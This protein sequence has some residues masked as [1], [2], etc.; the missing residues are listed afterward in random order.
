MPCRICSC[1][2]FACRDSMVSDSSESSVSE[3]RRS[4]Y[5]PSSSLT[6]IVLSN[7]GSDDLLDGGRDLGVLAHF[8]KSQTPPGRLCERIEQ[9]RAAHGEVSARVAD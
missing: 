4:T 8:V 1:S 5:P 7:F 9:W 2:T 6:S 3:G